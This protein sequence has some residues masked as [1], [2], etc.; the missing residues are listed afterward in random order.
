M[1][2]ILESWE[3][4]ARHWIEVLDGGELESRKLVTNAAVVNAIERWCPGLVLDAGCGEGWLCRALQRE[5]IA[6]VGV[7]G[8]AEL[9]HEARVKGDGHYEHI[10]FEDLVHYTFWPVGYFD[11]VVFNFCLY[12]NELTQHLLKA[13]LRWVPVHGKLVVQTLHPVSL[14]AAGEPYE[15]GWRKER[16]AGLSRPFTHPYRWY[17]R[18]VGSW[19]DTIMKSGWQLVKVD[20]PTHPRTGQPASL[21]IT[22]EKP[23]RSK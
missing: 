2:D 19:V 5:G 18:T 3:A 15:D 12:E 6:T 10:S 16:W 9:V 14:L 4:N 1:A 11:V 21:L 8:V 20:E 13:A 22:A 23:M 7:D 17:F